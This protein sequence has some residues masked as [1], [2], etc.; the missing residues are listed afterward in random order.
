MLT[1]HEVHEV[2]ETEDHDVNPRSGKRVEEGA[3]ER[4]NR[5]ARRVCAGCLTRTA[6]T[7]IRGRYVT[8]DDHDLCR[9]CWRTHMDSGDATRLARR[10]LH[11]R[12][13][14]GR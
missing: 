10:A 3:G 4:S 14:R 7:R 2:R 6:R 11:E 13:G 12:R 1:I 5:S 9:Q 8:R